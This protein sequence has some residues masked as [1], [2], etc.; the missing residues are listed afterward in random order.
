[1]SGNINNTIREGNGY[2]YKKGLQD[3]MPI[4]MGYFA[5][6]FTLGITAKNIGMTPIQAAV[7][8]MLL[9]ASAAVSY[10]HLTLPTSLIV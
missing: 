7:S 8:S 10:T 5:V 9:H 4:A 3:G 2:W 1:M 6:A